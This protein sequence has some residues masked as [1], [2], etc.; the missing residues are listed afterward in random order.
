MNE[1]AR[2]LLVQA[3]LDGVPRLNEIQAKR[4]SDGRMGYC[5]LGVL[6]DMQGLS[7]HAFSTYDIGSESVKCPECEKS[8]PEWVLL[9]HLNNDPNSW[10]GGHSFDFL[11]TARKYPVLERELKEG[12]Q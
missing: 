1:K 12:K 6:L 9:C 4:L 7:Y 3:H 11:T 10:S 2:E 8:M 5:A